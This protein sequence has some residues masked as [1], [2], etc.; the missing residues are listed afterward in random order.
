MLGKK[1][2]SYMQKVLDKKTNKPK[3]ESLT[4]SVNDASIL[5]SKPID[6]SSRIP[7][8]KLNAVVHSVNFMSKQL[9][10]DLEIRN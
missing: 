6:D 3:L 5:Y 10:A 7:G 4:R 2:P 9:R 8:E 1:V